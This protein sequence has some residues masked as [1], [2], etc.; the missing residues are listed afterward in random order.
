MIQA[1]MLES[2]LRAEPREERRGSSRFQI[3]LPVSIRNFPSD[4]NSQE[5][6]G[7]TMDISGCGIYFVTDAPLAPGTRLTLTIA[8]PR[9]QTSSGS[10][11][12]CVRVRVVRSEKVWDEGERRVGAAA[13][14]EHYCL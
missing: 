10:V 13:E 4:G 7:K 14:I 9:K 8:F 3:A 12:A 5:F 2:I 11:L 1:A 6:F